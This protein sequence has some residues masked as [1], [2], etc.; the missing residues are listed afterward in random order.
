MKRFLLSFLFLSF[1]F[2]LDGVQTR[3]YRHDSY[4][5]FVSGEFEN[6]S[7][8][9]TGVLKLA[10]ALEEL[11]EISAPIVWTAIADKDGNLYLGTGNL[12]KILKVD[13]EGEISTMFSPEEVLSRALAIDAEGNLFV[14]T[15]PMG[16]VY[17]ITPGGRPEI[18]FDP[19]ESYIWNLLFDKEGSLYVATGSE[20]VIYKLPENFQPEDE[21]VIWFECEQS[22]LTS[23]AWDAEGNLLAGSSPEG[24]LYRITGNGKGFALYNTGAQEIKQ[25]LAREDGGIYFSTFSTKQVET[26][27]G[28]VISKTKGENSNS[29]TV[30]AKRGEGD[31]SRNLVGKKSGSGSSMI[32]FM[33]PEG[34]VEAY[35]GLPNAH[36]FSLVLSDE[37]RLIVGTNDQGRIFSIEDRGKWSLLQQ[38]PEGGE[39]SVIL[40]SD[41]ASGAH[42]LFSSNPAKMYRMHSEPA[43]SGTYI[44]AVFDAKQISRW[45]RLLP[46]S[47]IATENH[48]E[49][50]TRS[51]NTGDPDKTW[52]DWEDV[53]LRGEGVTVSS[54]VARYLQYQFGFNSA[55]FSDRE[56]GIQQVRIFYQSKNVAPYIAAIRIV[57][58][59]FQLLKTVANQPN[60]D[61][62]KLI[63][64]KDTE[65][66][67]KVPPVRQQLR[68]A[69]EEGLMSVAWKSF[70]SN[71]DALTYTLSI[72]NTVNP[73]WI[74][75]VEDLKDPVATF[76][77]N[78]FEEGYYRVKVT[79][80]DE[81]D[82]EENQALSGYRLSEVFLID[83]SPPQVSVTERRA[84][85]ESLHL[86]FQSVD[87]FSINK[88][89]FY[90][91]DGRPAQ[92]IRPIDKL[93]DSKIERFQ[94]MIDS[95]EEGSHSLV[96]EVYDESGRS[97]VLTVPF[98]I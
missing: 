7:L 32:F 95:L 26:K 78:G 29:Y 23:L 72:K 12:G 27:T 54:P 22:H 94:L 55:D 33:D 79:A 75:L 97:G 47:E 46:L 43:E 85:Q 21:P 70:D 9:N 63:D 48:E 65:K 1:P 82:N 62:A 64:E 31:S 25:I 57:P 92:S 93:F 30:T 81:S 20:A 44:S 24:I 53:T 58:I 71:G 90:I 80:S 18:Y 2:S 4:E 61:L 39:I 87:D 15:S 28:S 89:A 96:L 42:Y 91:L 67:L 10:P 37:N 74:V 52:S 41:D 59:G 5:D 50:R 56:S 11:V 17:R 34:F 83:N 77:T 19:P 45:G 13:T 88:A 36:I 69:G 14:G 16:R 73:D 49:F 66:L 8:S 40:K 6:V 98:E 51:G 86:E 84:E 68:K 35:W 3:S 76:N 60:I 38:A